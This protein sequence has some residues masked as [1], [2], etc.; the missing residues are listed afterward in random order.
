M[1]HELIVFCFIYIY[2]ML[3]VRWFFPSLLLV[4]PQNS[5]IIR[6]EVETVIFTGCY[7]MR[8]KESWQKNRFYLCSK[9]SPRKNTENMPKWPYSVKTTVC[10]FFKNLSVLWV[11]PSPPPQPYRPSPRGWHSVQALV[12]IA[13][14]WPLSCPAVHILLQSLC[15]LYCTIWD[16]YTLSEVELC[17]LALQTYCT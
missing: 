11:T 3:V 17:A 13:R 8:R 14:Y 9:L 4:P 5:Q 1:L 16:K 10:I 12:Q 15:V 7:L 2:Y 6:K